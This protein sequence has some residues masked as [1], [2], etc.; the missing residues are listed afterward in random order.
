LRADRDL[1]AGVAGTDPAGWKLG[2]LAA[3]EKRAGFAL[4]EAWFREEHPTLVVSGLLPPAPRRPTGM[5]WAQDE[6]LWEAVKAADEPRR[7][8]AFAAAARACAAFADVDGD[9]S[10]RAVIDTVEASGSSEAVHREA[11][12]VA[13]PLTRDMTG[14]PKPENP[15]WRRLQAGAA[16]CSLMQPVF[17]YPF[18]REESEAQQTRWDGLAHAAYALGDSWPEVRE[19]VIRIL[20]D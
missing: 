9:L 5:L 10:L 20:Q 7:C 1:I 16:I 14:K 2:Y 13:A 11:L 19:R 18:P 8:R 17:E 3:L 4:S 6:P 15:A 12:V